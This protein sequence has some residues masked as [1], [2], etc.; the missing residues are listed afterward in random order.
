[1][2]VALSSPPIGD[3]AR[4]VRRGVTWW[5]D[6]LA[7]LLPRRLSRLLGHEPEPLILTTIGPGGGAIWR[8]EASRMST[9]PGRTPVT[10]AIDASLVFEASL[11]LPR[12]A[13][14]SLR[15]ILEH[16]IER[17]VPLTAGETR[18]D[19]RVAPGADDNMIRVRVFIAKR[20][21]LDAALTTA[22]DA[23]LNPRR[24]VIAGWR[25]PGPP[26]TLWESDQI[27]DTGRAL[28]RRMEIAALALAALAY[29]LYLHRLDQIR[30]ELQ[31]R[32]AAA[33][34]AAE[35][36]GALARTLAGADARRT[37]AMTPLQI[38]DA[39]T[40]L[41]PNNSWLT[42]LVLDHDT[43]EISGYSPNAS[44]LVELVEH[45]ALFRN[46]RFSS[47]ITLAPDGK[48][49]H[50]DLTFETKRVLVR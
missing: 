16:Q 23:G 36:V 27:T 50:F 32:V 38:I 22:R 47:P 13:R 24:I 45:S 9:H 12:A 25:E 1:M 48:R 17:L 10:I 26:P 37:R 33:Q 34:P 8:S 29:G 41:V 14:R 3:L 44:A 31:A 6:E 39:V 19:F 11:D 2:T 28:R 4:L 43:I 5:V 49:E 21:A 35:T 46:P 20:S 42:G 40:M 18:F 30:D 15:P 7:Q